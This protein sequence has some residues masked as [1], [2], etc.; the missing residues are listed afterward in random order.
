MT[1]AETEA[2]IATILLLVCALW[3]V[4]IHPAKAQTG[5][6]LSP[7]CVLPA[8]HISAVRSHSRRFVP[9]ERVT[10]RLDYS[11]HADSDFSVLFDSSN[12]A[13]AMQGPNATA[14]VFDSTV[15]GELLA[16]VLRTDTK[17][18]LVVYSLRNAVVSLSVNGHNDSRQAEQVGTE[19]SQDVFATLNHQGRVRSV[20]F[21]PKVSNL[22]QSFLRT[23]LALTQFVSPRTKREL[24]RGRWEAQEDDPNGTYLARYQLA[25]ATDQ[26]PGRRPTSSPTDYL[27]TKLRY[28]EPTE[29]NKD[30]T[31]L[32]QSIVPGGMLLARFAAGDEHLR[33]LKGSESKLILMAGK[34]VARSNSTLS[35]N[36]VDAE[37]IEPSELSTLLEASAERGRVARAMPLSFSESEE[38]TEAA[39]QRTELGDATLESLLSD[40]SRFEEASASASSRTSLYLKLK[41]LA[42][43]HPEAC[44]RMGTV[45]TSARAKSTTMLII[46]GAL[47]ASGH[48][49]AQAAL[50]SAIEDHAQDWPA[51][52]TLIP[53]LGATRLPTPRT[54]EVL[55]NLAFGSPDFNIAST[56]QLALGTAA[57]NLRDSSP[58]RSARIVGR[59]IKK[60][61]S[62]ASE[63]EKVQ[64][65]SA[66]GNTGAARA[67]PVINRFA[68]E[69]SPRLRAA[70]LSALRLVNDHQADVLLARAL[71]SDPDA[72]V[73]L[74]AAF[75]LGFREM[76]AATYK[77]QRRVF[78][79]DR[80]VNVRLEVLQNL[81]RAHE[82]FP[83]VRQIVKRAATGDAA[84][85]IRAAASRII[86]TCRTC[87]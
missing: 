64:L 48:A 69:S 46:S 73:R 26:T 72:A 34:T 65:L 70:A 50:A 86:S 35:L 77:A 57:R 80:S 43:L 51:L 58:E 27:K 79:S 67:L 41:A 25:Q 39:V 84:E 5:R 29:K 45:L 2:R 53:A 76:N 52:A 21:A 1:H 81:W 3:T 19:L 37:T 23:L 71:T 15:R 18:T 22:F 85:E 32:A 17:D 40:L 49:E 24:A 61:K 14:Y 7:G 42:Y 36:Y 44:A 16:T 12:P 75:T 10:Y 87:F 63:N 11:N 6:C 28:L 31:Q 66:L 55:L 4:Q 33:S 82:A 78:L 9:G 47:G 60:L 68:R 59:I 83:D 30:S 20:C 62:A 13:S 56:A 38:A 74:D 54:E 8:F